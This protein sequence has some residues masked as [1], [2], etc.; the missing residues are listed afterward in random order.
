M[1]TEHLWREDVVKGVEWLQAEPG[2]IRPGFTHELCDLRKVSTLSVPQFFT[3]KMGKTIHTSG[4]SFRNSTSCY[5]HGTEVNAWDMV[6][7]V[8][9]F[10]KCA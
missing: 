7:A 8:L 1:F 5:M 4:G 6:S 3:F 2:A 9:V 10:F